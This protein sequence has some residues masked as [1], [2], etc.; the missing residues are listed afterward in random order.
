MEE[1]SL[2]AE[3]MQKGSLQAEVLQKVLKLVVHE[4]MC[5]GKE[6]K[7]QMRREK[8]MDGLLKR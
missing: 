1:N 8:V 2:Q 7:V 3:V 5:Q 6:V 4:R